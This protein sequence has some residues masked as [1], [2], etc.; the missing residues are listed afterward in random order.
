VYKL[1]N[2]LIFSQRNAKAWFEILVTCPMLFWD[3]N[4]KLCANFKWVCIFIFLLPTLH[5]YAQI[6]TPEYLAYMR[7]IQGKDSIRYNCIEMLH[8]NKIEETISY[9]KNNIR[10]KVGTEE[11]NNFGILMAYARLENWDSI[12]IYANKI[13]EGT[14]W[15]DDL[16]AQFPIYLLEDYFAL[17]KI[18]DTER[19]KKSVKAYMY[20]YYESLGYDKRNMG[21]ELMELFIKDQRL[22]QLCIYKQA[23]CTDEPCRD[24]ILASY[25][26]LDSI[27]NL[28]FINLLKL[29]GGL[30]TSSEIG[31][32]CASY[33][34]I[35]IWHMQDS[36]LRKSI[37]TPY[38]EKAYK[39]GKI[40][41]RT[42]ANNVIKTLEISRNYEPTDAEKY[43]EYLR[44]I[45]KRYN[46]TKDL[47]VFKYSQ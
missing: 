47:S 42:L 37:I 28:K 25:L 1:S 43:I 11:Q 23:F 22:R 24:T 46:Y 30:Y 19:Y 13:L 27:N 31:N 15:A 18:L 14:A 44:D 45:A 4:I 40:E 16:N 12:L 35:M 6:G 7:D 2:L 8:N 36:N 9:C 41:F 29:H 26:F 21:I 20:N 32:V 38:L 10:N 17:G 5:G 3:D 34:N 33:Q 39:E